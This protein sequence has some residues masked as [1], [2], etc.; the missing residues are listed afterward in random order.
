MIFAACE[1]AAMNCRNE[2]K[3][4]EALQTVHQHL[5]GDSLA[6]ETLLANARDRLEN[7]ELYCSS[8]MSSQKHHLST[9]AL[10]VESILA[11]GKLLLCAVRQEKISMIQIKRLENVLFPILFIRASITPPLLRDFAVRLPW[12]A[13]MDCT[14]TS[15]NVP[16]EKLWKVLRL[17][18]RNHGWEFLPSKET[19][20]RTE[21]EQYLVKPQLAEVGTL[22]EVRS[23]HVA[24][25]FVAPLRAP[26]IV[27]VNT[28][29]KRNVT[30]C[31]PAYLLTKR[32]KV[33]IPDVAHQ[34]LS[35]STTRTVLPAFTENTSPGLADQAECLESETLALESPIKRRRIDLKINIPPSPDRPQR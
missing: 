29:P 23:K 22:A 17:W 11:L 27:S 4:R 28:G 5:F 26:V 25:A 14:Q 24:A 20:S 31:I 7:M 12:K 33:K 32:R 30:S 34:H 1:A 8:R 18:Q 2:E 21:E 3:L 35:G 19:N 16:A 13:F 15:G 6:G 10:L 9:E